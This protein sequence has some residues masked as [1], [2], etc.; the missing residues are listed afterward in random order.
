M[1]IVRS[2]SDFRLTLALNGI[3]PFIIFIARLVPKGQNDRLN[4]YSVQQFVDFIVK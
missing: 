3:D 1:V 4:G 2:A